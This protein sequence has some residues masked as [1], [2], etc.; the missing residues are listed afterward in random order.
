MPN[1]S[2]TSKKRRSTSQRVNALVPT[3]VVT[4][5]K[6]AAKAKKVTL[7]WVIRD[8]LESYVSEN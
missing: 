3:T 1:A 4:K 5:M 2:S 6:A 7:A 8:A